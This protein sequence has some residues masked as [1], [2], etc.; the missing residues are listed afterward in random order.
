M[1]YNLPHREFEKIIDEE[2]KPMIPN[3]EYSKQLINYSTKQIFLKFNILDDSYK[4]VYLGS[5]GSDVAYIKI[6]EIL[7][8]GYQKFK[9]E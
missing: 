1:I 3:Y 5:D 2:I 8:L 4:L 6:C 9:K 7:E